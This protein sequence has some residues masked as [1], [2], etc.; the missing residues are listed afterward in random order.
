MKKFTEEEGLIRFSVPAEG[1]IG[2]KW[3]KYFE[4]EGIGLSARIRN[5]IL[6]GWFKPTVG[7]INFVIVRGDLFPE[8]ECNA[9]NVRRFAGS[10][11]LKLL[12]MESVCII[13]KY[14]SDE[15]LEVIGISRILIMSK[16]IL[17]GKKRFL[18]RVDKK[19]AQGCMM[20]TQNILPG[21][22]YGQLMGFAF[23]E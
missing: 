2:S 16:V 15:D 19:N 21:H 4:K 3:L 12:E 23:C 7:M 22:L 5:M 14:F 11:K 8:G 6:S 13:R 9:R 1:M 10:K 20:G 18:T 17:R